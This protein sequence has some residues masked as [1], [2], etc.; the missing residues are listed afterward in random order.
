V[1]NVIR[2]IA[3]CLERAPLCYLLSTLLYSAVYAILRAIIRSKPLKIQKSSAI[4]RHERGK[5]LS[6][7]LTFGSIITFVSF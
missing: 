5:D 7:F 2:S 4:G 6:F 3:N 1:N